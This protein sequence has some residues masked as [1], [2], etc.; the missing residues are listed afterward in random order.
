MVRC[1]GVKFNVMALASECML[2]CKN[3]F[4]CYTTSYNKN[5]YI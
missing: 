5:M 2:K 3:L 1:I 4:L